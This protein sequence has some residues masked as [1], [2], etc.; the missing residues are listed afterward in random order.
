MAPNLSTREM[1]DGEERQLILDS[2]PTTPKRRP[3]RPQ[4][5]ALSPYKDLIVKL[6][7]EV[8][9]STIGISKT[10][11]S[12]MDLDISTRTISRLLTAWKVPRKRARGPT[13]QEFQSLQ[14]H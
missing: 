2:D 7:S 3:G 11:N 14:F 10:L 5:T 8:N 12:E 1:N 13:S 6:F 9:K 4:K